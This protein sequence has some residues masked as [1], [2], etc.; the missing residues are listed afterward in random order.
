MVGSVGGGTLGRTEFDRA[1]GWLVIHIE[2]E[3]KR[4]TKRAQEK[5]GKKTIEH[6]VID[7]TVGIPH[8]GEVARPL[9]R[10]IWNPPYEIWGDSLCK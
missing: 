2:S 6:Q 1:M 5:V 7:E 8:K 10:P 4:N 3:E 9:V